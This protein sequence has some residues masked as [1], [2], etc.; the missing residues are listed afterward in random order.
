M[1]ERKQPKPVK[2]IDERFEEREGEVI[3]RNGNLTLVED[4]ETGE[5]KWLAPH[6][7]EDH[8]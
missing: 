5:P 7:V 2:Y 8:D 6:E 4:R 3:R 1:R